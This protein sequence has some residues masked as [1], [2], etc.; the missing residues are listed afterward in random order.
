MGLVRP[1]VDAKPANSNIQCR[2]ARDLSHIA[3]ESIDLVLTDPPYFDYISY[4]ELGHFFAP[5][6]ARF[7]LI[8]RTKSKRL[9]IA[10][11]ASKARSQDAERRF[12][13]RLAQAFSEM[14]RV[15]RSDGRVVF[16]YQNL[17]GRGWNAIAKA[18]ATSGVHPIQTFPLYGDSST[19]LHKHENSISWDCVMVCKLGPAL[20]N[21][22]VSATSLK[23][24]QNCADRWARKLASSDFKLTDGDKKNI[25]SAAS[26]VTEF[27]NRDKSK[28]SADPHLWGTNSKLLRRR[29]PATAR[30]G[31]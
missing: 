24:G 12:A 3:D 4:S 28:G 19:R 15:C 5:W 8:D 17:D 6:L 23:E 7:G 14:K 9:P 31:R 26:I 30:Q 22:E 11:L 2:D 10:Q 16:T 21:F 27:A 25:A 1:V 29:A 13:K 20:Q 18:L